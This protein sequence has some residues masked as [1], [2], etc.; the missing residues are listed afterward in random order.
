MFHYLRTQR[1]LSISK[2]AQQSGLS[3]TTLTALDR[4]RAKGIS[5]NTLQQVTKWLDCTPNDLFGFGYH[6]QEVR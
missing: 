3:R 4:G 1:G 5:F 2:I 6:K